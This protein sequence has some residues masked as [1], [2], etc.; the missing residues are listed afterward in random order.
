LIPAMTT[1]GEVRFDAGL[2]TAR[3]AAGA[4][5]LTLLANLSDAGKAK[6]AMA[7]GEPIWGGTPPNE[8]PPWSV[9]AAIAGG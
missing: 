9:Y 4:K 3:W 8:L 2:L 6:P 7:W 5:M 1:P